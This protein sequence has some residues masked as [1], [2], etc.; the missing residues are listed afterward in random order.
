M[1]RNKR[2]RLSRVVRNF[3]ALH[4]LEAHCVQT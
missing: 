2:R 3:L 4:S 1:A